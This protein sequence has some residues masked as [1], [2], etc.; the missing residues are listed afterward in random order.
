MS[1]FRSSGCTTTSIKGFMKHKLTIDQRSLINRLLDEGR[2][3]NTIAH[4]AGVTP[5]Q[6]SA[7]AAHRTMRRH[8]RARSADSL[9]SLQ[10]PTSVSTATVH[11]GGIQSTSIPLGT[12]ID[13]S[14]SVT[15]SLYESTNPHVLILGESGSGKTYTASRL[16]LE[17]ARAGLPSII[18]DYGQGFTLQ[19]APPQFRND[20]RTIELQLARD[21]I[22]INPLQIFPVDTHGPATVAQRV[23]DTFTRVYPKLGV[24]QHALLRRA[25][26][27]L[28]ADA[29]IVADDPRT[30]TRKPPP[31]RE[32]EDKVAD[33]ANA[34]ESIT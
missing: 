9:M 19:H 11:G 34:D 1:A 3:R 32:L 16:V 17:L 23:A 10:G 24:Q 14:T 27:A 13:S 2:D 15:W 28:L 25:V 30:W 12:D 7:I 21:G 22:A 29:G 20:M 4:M 33:L 26:L 5:N 18:F 6:V 8:E 31:F